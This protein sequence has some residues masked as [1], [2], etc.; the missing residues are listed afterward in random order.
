MSKGSSQK[1]G[2]LSE[3]RR[4]YISFGG[5]IMR[6]PLVVSE[7][8]Y[9]LGIAADETVMC[10]DVPVYGDIPVYRGDEAD[11]LLLFVWGGKL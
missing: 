2:S 11:R 7:Y 9:G 10:C 4:R 1:T 6:M 8:G 5:K 3:A